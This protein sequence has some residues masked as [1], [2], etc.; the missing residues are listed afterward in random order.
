MKKLI[1]VLLVLA[2]ALGMLPAALADGPVEVEYL[3]GLGGNLGN[4]FLSL[5]DEYNNSQSAVKVIPIQVPDYSTA[6]QQYQA[7]LAAGNPPAMWH[8]QMARMMKVQDYL[9]PLNDRYENDAEF[10]KDDIL[11][12]CL[13]CMYGT[14]GK[15][16]YGAPLFASTQ[17]MYYR[18]DAFEGYDI[19]ETFSTWQNLA[20]AAAE[21]AAADNG[22]TWGWMPMW[23]T[24]NWLDAVCSAGGG[25][26]T[27]ETMRQVNYLS[28]EWID[29]MT[30][31]RK[32][33]VEDQIMSMHHGG[34]GWEY[35]YANIDDVLEGTSAGYTGSAGDQGDLDFSIVGVHKQP[36]W[37][38]HETNNTTD[39]H[40]VVIAKSIPEEKKDAA[41]D[42]IKF[43]SK[44]SSQARISMT[45]GYV[46]TRASAQ[47]DPTFAAYIAE[48]PHVGITIDAMN[49]T[50][51]QPMD[52]TGGYIDSAYGDMVDRIL[53]EGED[54]I[55]S[56]TICQ[57]EAQ[58]ALDEFWANVDA[59]G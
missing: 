24:D 12:G 13:S 14:D 5:I 51:K 9:E 50:C 21:I 41:W 15:T 22:I 53:L 30:S 29:V 54:V 38:D 31:F 25:K 19:E 7:G 40:M 44:P 6:L 45:G 4:L 20:K 52:I 8:A 36:G 27:D 49:Y 42:F 2:L 28:D 46:V 26:Y 10:N 57:E 32:W 33:M 11:A 55:E 18:K 37:G 47:E 16:I 3:F 17:L 56:L 1:T 43:L 48:N 58:A 23:S 39:T 34:S 35:W 59:G